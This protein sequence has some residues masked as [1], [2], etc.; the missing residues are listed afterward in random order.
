MATHRAPTPSPAA[1]GGILL[2]GS[3][4]IG[5]T[6][7]AYSQ[8]SAGHVT[9]IAL[10]GVIAGLAALLTSTELAHGD[11]RPRRHNAYGAALVTYFLCAAVHVLPPGTQTPL[12][13]ITSLAYYY[14]IAVVLTHRTDREASL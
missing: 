10:T 1:V 12:I 3:F 14:A 5:T 11:L 4:G 9:L 6:A 2:L 13:I 7:A 8:L